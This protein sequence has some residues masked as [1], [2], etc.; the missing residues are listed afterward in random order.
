[1]DITNKS[2]KLAYLLRHDKE[3]AFDGQGYREVDDLIKHHGFT[4]AMLE[5]IVQE[6]NKRRFE[7]NEN[8]TKIRARQGHSVEVDVELKEATPPDVLYHGTAVNNRDSIFQYGIEK[9][10][11]L[12]VH[13]SEEIETAKNVGSRH[14]IPIVYAIDCKRMVDDGIKFYL[15]ANNVWLTEYV[16]PKYLQEIDKYDTFLNELVNK[17]VLNE[18]L[19]FLREK[20]LEDIEWD[21]SDIGWCDCVVRP[22]DD[23]KANIEWFNN[24]GYDEDDP[25]E[26]LGLELTQNLNF[27]DTYPPNYTPFFYNHQIGLES[28][29][30]NEVYIN[31]WCANGENEIDLAIT[32]IPIF[33]DGKR[34]IEITYVDKL[35]NK[36][37]NKKII[38]DSFMCFDD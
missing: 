32:A 37:L 3:Y 30:H 22:H 19:L 6:N 27:Y 7:F 14:G 20:M 16:S 24:M 23:S 25:F 34:L 18:K 38:E 36:L 21:V 35:E 5:A 11:R 8:K 26:N 33:K 1:M 9:G 4:M 13:L 31:V 29:R 2:R 15:S 10:K 12:H 28:Y 17:K